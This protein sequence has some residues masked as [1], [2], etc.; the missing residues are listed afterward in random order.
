MIS[1]ITPTHKPCV[2]LDLTI[3]SVLYQ[4][5]DDFEWVILDNSSDG[6]FE[7]YLNN[8]FDTY[9]YLRYLRSK[10]HVHRKIYEDL[11]IGKIKNDLVEL[12]N[13]GEE[14]YVLLLDH[15]D[16]LDNK[17]L[18]RFYDMSKCYP[19]ADY[20]TGDYVR[21]YC[22]LPNYYL[23]PTYYNDELVTDNIRLVSGELNL[24]CG[25]LNYDFGYINNY[26]YR[27][28]DFVIGSD[29]N[30]RYKLPNHPRC[31]RK[32]R[33]KDVMYRFYE[34]T[35]IGDDF[36]QTVMIGNFLK[37]CWVE[38]PTVLNVIYEDDNNKN[39]FKT[40]YDDNIQEYLLTEKR[41][42]RLF[43]ILEDLFGETLDMKQNKRFLNIIK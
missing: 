41:L 32:H 40:Y 29:N 3:K 10:I 34:G 5:Y 20:I 17:A 27:Y 38:H 35:K 14:E 2:M 28:N 13:C 43:F 25:E 15:D 23:S 8:F 12:T 39:T 18:E 1:I 37:G 26:T 21:L 24:C 36:V 19:T 4:T 16:L 30:K 9:P 7:S 6:Y 22:C 42:D 11:C 31:I 33:S